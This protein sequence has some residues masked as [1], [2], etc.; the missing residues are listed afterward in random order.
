MSAIVDKLSKVGNFFKKVKMELKKVNW[1]SKKDLMS[2]TAVV[3][4]TVSLLVIFIGIIDL[5]FGQIITPII[6]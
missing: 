1:P 6:M 2:Y 5:I 4:I 3:L